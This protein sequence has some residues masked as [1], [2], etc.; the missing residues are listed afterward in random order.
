MKQ[1]DLDLV[2]VMLYLQCEDPVVSR[3]AIKYLRAE[4]LSDNDRKQL[5]GITPLDRDEF[6]LTM[7]ERIGQ[8]VWAVSQSA[9]IICVDQLEDIWHTAMDP[10]D[11]GRKFCNAMSGLQ[12]VA[13]NVPN[14]IV[15]IACLED[16]YDKLRSNLTQPIVD[17]IEMDP[18]PLYLHAHRSEDEIQ[19]L[20]TRH[21]S[22]FYKEL[23][24]DI[25]ERRPTYPLPQTILDQGKGKRARDFLAACKEYRDE[26]IKLWQHRPSRRAGRRSGPR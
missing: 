11:S 3:R 19:Q 12:Q 4:S 22:Y 9:L 10:G 18:P 5:G 15:V 20:A 6:A 8:L 2:H 25:D 1:V 13:S 24:I 14:A 21:L 23:D 16:Y 26:C 7:I 17:R